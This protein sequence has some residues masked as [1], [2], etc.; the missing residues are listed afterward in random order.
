[1][2]IQKEL[3][4]MIEKHNFSIQEQALIYRAY[5]IA[6]EAHKG[7]LRKSGEP[8]IIHPIAVA[9]ILA[10]YGLDAVT[11]AASLVHD[12]PEDSP[13]F[14]LSYIETHLGREIAFIVD[15]VTKIGAVLSNDK[16]ELNA[17]TIKKLIE[18]GSQDIR[19]ILIKIA[20]RLHNMRTMQFQ[21]LKKQIEKSTETMLIY[22]PI[23][24]MLGLGQIKKELNDLAL[25]YI[26]NNA[27]K[28]TRNS[29]D[30]L[31]K[32]YK[33]SISSLE[34]R[35]DDALARNDINATIR[36][37]K[38]H[39][40]E[41]YKESKNRKV[42]ISS[43]SSVLSQAVIVPTETDCYRT[44]GIIHKTFPY[45]QKDGIKDYIACPKANAYSSLHTTLF[46]PNRGLLKIKIRTPEQDKVAR[47]G[48]MGILENKKYAKQQMQILENF[49]KIHECLSDGTY[50]TSIEYV[51]ILKRELMERITVYTPSSEKINLPYGSTA[52]D[53]AS[54][55]HSELCFKALGCQINN[56]SQVKDLGTILQD[57]DRVE[58]ITCNGKNKLSPY[59]P[60][61]LI[62]YTNNIQLRK[63]ILARKK[64][65]SS[66]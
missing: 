1:M 42:A 50:E 19:V 43:L 29:V 8:Y 46:L 40:G 10:S 15:G 5:K 27:Y 55:I 63:K 17:E 41:V 31:Y 62:K 6:L 57:G 58:I 49:T 20:D 33:R 48:I 66:F 21:P 44:L 9:K 2:C 53:F 38:R 45:F 13:N 25:E 28:T 60:E 22:V 14:P 24:D 64:G 59:D 18:Y 36:Q 51:E 11:I 26:N 23:A 65:L 32:K 56:Q 30:N 47:E 12:V 54:A 35:F 61:Q 37:E 16:K 52:L 7:V 4:E 39:P 3:E 34:K